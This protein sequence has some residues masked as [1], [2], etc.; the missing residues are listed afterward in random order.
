MR[1]TLTFLFAALLCTQMFAF[2][3]SS[4]SDCM[5]NDYVGAW[6]KLKLVG[7]QLS[8]ESGEPVQLRGWST[9]GRQ[10]NGNRYESKDFLTEQKKNGAN[11]ARI[12]M[13]VE[14]G[15]WK[16]EDWIKKCIDWTAELNM[17]C[18]VDWHVLTPGKPTEYLG[19]DPA[20][21]FKNIAQY[22]KDKSYKHVLYELCNE[23]NINTD[24]DIYR[25]ELW[26]DIKTYANKILPEIQS[27]DPDA[28]VIV[29]TPQWDQAL[30]H[31]VEEP[32]KG[33]S[34][35]IMYTFHS[36]VGNQAQYFGE[37][38]T[39][40][41]FIP[42]FITEWGTTENL[43]QSNYSEEN[44]D[45][46]LDICNGNNRGGVKISW[47]NWSWSTEGGMSASLSGN[48]FSTSGRYI[49]GKLKAGDATSSEK[50]STP[51]NMQ[52]ISA[53][54]ESFIY[55]EN[56]D[57]GGEGVAYHESD[58]ADWQKSSYASKHCNAG[59][60]SSDA[61]M[62]NDFHN[63]DCVDVNYID[64]NKE[65]CNIGYIL[66]GEWVKFTINVE[67]AGYYRLEPYA[68]AHNSA[69]RISFLVDNENAIRDLNDRENTDV[70][71][72]FMKPNG[73]PSDDGG[74]GDWGYSKFVSNFDG[75]DESATDY[76]LYFDKAGEQ[77]LLITFMT[78]C[79]GLGA[80]KLTPADPSTSVS[81]E[82]ANKV[83]ASVSSD[84]GNIIINLNGN[85]DNAEINIISVSG[86]NIYKTITSNNVVEINNLESGVYFAIIKANNTT[87]RE[88]VVVY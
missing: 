48:G 39:A 70:N 66:S 81:D 83:V 25:P 63:G 57:N 20:G 24:G 44:A 65:M 7:N 38:Q 3:Y 29:G 15:G 4:E 26:E 13:Y 74:Y 10:W 12:A 77:T 23:P 2:N 41:K 76:G 51:Y 37:L 11:I 50:A 52:T 42:V 49:S 67:K 32:F 33:Y 86:I 68:N 43:G 69:N 28:V 40:A 17:Y 27:V 59:I 79:A 16:D 82:A 55:M 87:I 85:T 54:E 84:K 75:K 35:N 19:K 71:V 88:K 30:V 31:A 73:T 9:H 34:L 56:Y 14:E 80:L 46:L 64:D 22:A 47:C 58:D 21:F 8:S 6:G 62:P 1:K 72:V 60:G 45:I 78:E 18:L 36:Y 53:T 5:S 61:R